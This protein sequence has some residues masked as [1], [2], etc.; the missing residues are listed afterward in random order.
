MQSKNSSKSTTEIEK[1]GVKGKQRCVRSELTAA[2]RRPSE[3]S[4]KDSDFDED[5]VTSAVT[6]CLFHEDLNGGGFL[7][8][9]RLKTT[10]FPA[11]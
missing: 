9:E 10:V 5:T 6:V 3:V 8:K 2:T 11:L 1:E 4:G 7:T